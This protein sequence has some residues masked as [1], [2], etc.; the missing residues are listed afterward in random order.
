MRDH[1]DMYLAYYFIFGFPIVGV[2]IGLV[3]G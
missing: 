1:I 2:V 3:Y